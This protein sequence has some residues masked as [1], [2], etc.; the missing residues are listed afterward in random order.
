[1]SYLAI[2]P[3]DTA[4]LREYAIA[5][6]RAFLGL[7]NPVIWDEPFL[8]RPGIANSFFNA[9][10]GTASDV[11]T[12]DGGWKRIACAAGAGSSGYIVNG[13]FSAVVANVGTQK[14]YQ[15]WVFRIPQAIDAE[16]RHQIGFIDTAFSADEPCLG[17][18][19]S[20]S[21]TK[22]RFFDVTA[23][24]DSSVSIDTAVHIGEHGG[25]GAGTI[26]GAIDGEA[27]KSYVTAKTAALT[28]FVQNLNGATGGV[29]A[30]DLGQCFVITD[31]S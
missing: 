3:G 5:R 27:T 30:T 10:S 18:Q 20:S 1:V 22:F 26:F 2:P 21:T 29:Q 7:A 4:S 17:V 15:L 12:L 11:T 25:N 23:G 24:V 9:V 31:Q 19:G 28:P 6:A 16:S 13:Q 8:N 14:W